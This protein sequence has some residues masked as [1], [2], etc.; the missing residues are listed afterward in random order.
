MGTYIRFLREKSEK[1]LNI[2][3]PADWFT[4]PKT[5]GEFYKEYRDRPIEEIR[6]VSFE[7]GLAV[8]RVIKEEMNIRGDNIEAIATLLGAVLK[9]EPT[10]K[11][12]RAEKDRLTLRNS[13]FCPLMTACLSMNLPW[14]WLCS[15]LGWPFFHGLASA[16]NPKVNLTMSKRREKGDPYCDHIF[17]IGQGCLIL[18]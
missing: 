16:I 3:I 8:G 9:D 2:T 13:G 7:Q 4:N 10:A 5:L 12:L 11:L 6:A 1:V 15:A 14:A 18:P 17:E